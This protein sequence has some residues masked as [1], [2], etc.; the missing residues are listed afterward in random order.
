[1][2]DSRLPSDAG[3]PSPPPP[4]PPDSG[5]A[6]RWEGALPRFSLDRRITV[7][8]LLATVLVVGA[9]A[10]ISIPLELIPSGF[11]PPFLSVSVPWSD[12][13]AP[14]VLEKVL[15]PLE[16]ELSTVR[17]LD[18]MSSFATTGF[19]RI[20]LSFRHGT[21]MDVA[22]REARDRV[23]RARPLLPDD[24]DRVFIRKE[25]SS[26]FPVAMVGVLIDPGVGDAYDL[27]QTE[28]VPRLERIDGV[29]AVG[30][31]GLIDKE[32]LIEIDRERAEA[33][34][35][36]IY[37][38][39]Q[40]L[41][42]DNFSL[43]SGHVESG[44]SKMLLRSVARYDSVAELENRLVAPSVR[45]RD[46]AA[47]RYEQPER[48]F[49]IRVNSKPAIALQVMK[50]GDANTL[51]TARAVARVVEEMA[52]N[53]R[54]SALHLELIMDQGDMIMESLG[55][56]L[57][58]G[59][60]GGI[61]AVVVL[62]FFLR[63]LRLTLIIALSIPLSIVLALTAMYFAGE[64]LNIL[65]LLGLMICVGLLV[66][67]SVV[68]A[69]NIFRLHREGVPR[70]EAVIRGAS[71]IG[72]AIVMATLTTVAV[73][74]PVSLVDGEAQFFLLRLSLPI[75]VSLVASLF[76]ALIFVP[77]SVYLTLPGKN[78]RRKG[79]VGRSVDAVHERANSVLRHAYEATLGRM[80]SGYERLLAFFLRRRLDLCLG[81][82][83]AIVVT[84]AV[85]ASDRVKIVD[86]DENEQPG[87]DIDVELPAGTSFEEAEAWFL[88][89]EKVLEAQKE[90]LGLE[91]YFFYHRT[92]WG[93]IEGWF[94][95]PPATDLT[96]RQV[97]ERV[98]AAL[99]EKPGV[100][101]H[102]GQEDET[103]DE[104]DDGVHAFT[105]NGE[106]PD[107]LERVA[108]ELEELFLT[109]PGVLGLKG[110][111]RE[112]A[113]TE[114]ALVVDRDR[115][116]RQQ[117]NPATIAGVVS[118]ALRGQQLPRFHQNG[119][120][121]DVRVRFEEADREQL[122]QLGSFAVPTET[123]ELVSLDSL[124]DT[125]MLQSAKVI[126]RLDKQIA[127]TITLELVEG[128]EDAAR[129][130]LIAL[131]A[132]LDLPEGVRFGGGPRS[133]GMD[134]GVL[135]LLFAVQVSILFIYL[136][137]GFL[138]ESFVLPLS[139]L[140]TIPLAGLG[141]VWTHLFAGRN[142]D[143]LGIVG[144]VLLVGVV[145]NNGIVLV[146]YVNRLRKEGHERTEALLLAATR[147]FRPIMMT[148]L[149]TIFGMIPLAMGQPSSIGLSYKS[150]GLT[151]I[152]GLGAATLLTLLVVPVTYTLFE[153]L[154]VVV[155][156]ALRGR[157]R[158]AVVG[159][160]DGGVA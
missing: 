153:D 23:Q 15:L 129:E 82:L 150:F 31:Q 6:S 27:I 56:L 5:S 128:E 30:S 156:A 32:V 151:L 21:D 65:S 143:M 114:L 3:H 51:E 91:G 12:A 58:S 110:S 96:P 136:L 83:A 152:G 116:Q 149:T 53:P 36:N 42:A 63:R 60:V 122:S 142:I 66:D 78:G 109:V 24:A 94:A 102:T 72:L 104:K 70:R 125:E 48:E 121:I 90:E 1:M 10:A 68:V 74:L 76:V 2:T 73:F 49:R 145:V 61:L 119:R 106:D 37:Q 26:G 40:Q 54:L 52:E 19:G 22:Y 77:L 69:E 28:V 130:R 155:R 75:S 81:V 108:E 44:G 133:E 16:E 158:V 111:G 80:N 79:A 113:P 7:L 13:P 20:A 154:G 99:P 4:D 127:R 126:R 8:V 93:E 89:V 86:Q 9:V 157:R 46:V 141:V 117:V 29:A 45:L 138:F 137:M 146:D 17:G 39:A 147:R 64:T 100:V 98:L 101:L 47:V 97:T 35:L 67:N 50:E 87:F 135:A 139:I 57:D 144:L 112:P 159:A 160:A 105:L 85:F 123:G 120:E 134:E 115:A 62:L 33:A 88:E 131:A 14:E 25:S 55:T 18:R 71:E 103:G 140:T 92:N 38:L 95:N 59:R 148:A 34:G 43:A 41:S 124:T 11:T 107:E 132:G 84:G 118:Y